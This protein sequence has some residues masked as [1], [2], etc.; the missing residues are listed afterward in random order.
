MVETN[1][2]IKFPK[3]IVEF[4]LEPNFMILS[5]HNPDGT[6]HSTVVW[7]E[8]DPKSGDFRISITEERVKYKNIL[9]DS[10]VTFL[11]PDTS[12]MYRYVQIQGE[13]ANITKENA[14]DF[15][16]S[17]SKRYLNKAT[18]P[19]EPNRD[20]PR[21]VVTLKSKSFFSIGFESSRK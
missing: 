16:D 19:H 21:I 2:L 1:N 18:Y 10:R 14:Y 6:I 9:Q 3:D 17:E 20:K 11:I 13:F 7:Y 4:L 15:L 5:E 12:N 8:F